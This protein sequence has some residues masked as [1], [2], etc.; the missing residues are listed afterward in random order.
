MAVTVTLP[1]EY[2][3]VMLCSVAIAFQC[4]VI[5]HVV[6][7]AMRFKTFNRDFMNKNFQELHQKEVSQ[8]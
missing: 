3:Y 5:G 2:G 7:Q 1:S 6:A 8:K 4:Y